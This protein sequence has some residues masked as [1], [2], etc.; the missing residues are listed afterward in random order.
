MTSH[1]DSSGTLTSHIFYTIIHCNTIIT[2][3]QGSRPE[4]VDRPGQVVADSL[5]L[6]EVLLL[7]ALLVGR[8]AFVAALVP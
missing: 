7:T 1:H 5:A 4:E 8:N 6:V 3:L 2:V